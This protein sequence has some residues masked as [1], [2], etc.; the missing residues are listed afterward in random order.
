MSLQDQVVLI[1]GGCKNLGALVARQFAAQGAR[2][3]LHYNSSNTRAAADKIAAELNAK[4]YQADLTTA[5][6]VHKLFEAVIDDLGQPDIVINTVGMVLKKSLIDISEDEYDRMFAVNSKS[7]F[8]ITQE[9]AKIVRDGGKIINIV[10]SLLAVYTEQY[11]SYQ[12][13]KAPVEW[14]TKGLS[15]ELIPRR[16]SV[17]AI[18]PGPM[19]TPFFYPQE[20]DDSVAFFKNMALGGRLTKIEDIVPIIK[21]LCTEGAWINGE[22]T[23]L[24][25]SARRVLLTF[26]QAKFCLP[27]AAWQADKASATT[28]CREV[29]LR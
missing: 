21:F 3:A 13:S 29:M 24:L 1:T 9:A 6:N 23:Y 22:S 11:T 19:D 18:A 10:T 16:I 26:D 27:M 8:F 5:S 7:A 20:S 25:L 17:N 28:T 15:K 12:G 4:V 14:F 2:L